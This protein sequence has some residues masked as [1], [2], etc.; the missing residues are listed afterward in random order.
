M[1][2]KTAVVMLL[3]VLILGLIG[4]TVGAQ[5]TSIPQGNPDAKISWPPPVYVL[6]GEVEVRGTANL[7]NM[8][9]YFLE[10]RPLNDDLTALADNVSWSPATLPSNRPV[11]DDILGVWNTELAEDGLYELRLTVN[12]SRSSA[13]FETVSPLRI[14]NNPPDFVILETPRP[15]GVTATSTLSI[16]TRPTLAATPTPFDNT[17]R[18]VANVDANVRSGDSTTYPP[19]GTLLAGDSARV[20]GISSS[21]SGWYYIELNSGR[22]GFIAPS[23]V[24]LTGNAGNLPRINPPAPPPPPPPPTPVGNGDL[25]INGAATS[26]DS[27]RCSEAFEFR[28]NITNAGNRATSNGGIVRM[29]HLD[30]STNTIT[31]IMTDDFPVMGVGQNF[32]V[33]FPVT[34]NI[35]GDMRVTFTIDP[36]NQ[37]LEENESNN[38]YVFDY[39]LRKGTCP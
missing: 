11:I 19:V 12:V 4:G 38:T 31:T 36:F 5:G 35:Y 7:A 9:N 33:T 10:F 30:L 26:V 29:E 27:A 14:E 39:R 28:A 23:I 22:R 15:V 21:G 2:K 37:V 20:L 34:L 16:I 18:V 24:T 3:A 13:I 6:R 1:Y 25:I 8:S 32:V 17:P